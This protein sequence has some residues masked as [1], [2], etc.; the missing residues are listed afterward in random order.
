MKFIADKQTLEDLNLLGRYKPHSIYSLFNQVK[1]SGGERLLEE[2]F[3]HPLTD[4]KS[5]NLRSR[6][7]KYFQDK[8]LQFPLGSEDFGIMENYLTMGTSGNYLSAIAKG[9]YN[10][11]TGSLLRDDQFEIVHSG[12][13]ASMAGLKVLHVFFKGLAEEPG[14]PYHEEVGIFNNILSDPRLG[15]LF[16]NRDAAP[17]SVMEVA[18]YDFLLRHT[19]KKHMEQMLG[20]IYKLD[21]YMAV[22]EVARSRGYRY[23]N[24]LPKSENRFNT[25]AL[26]HPGLENA[27]ANPLSFNSDHNLLFLTGAN[28]AGKSTFMKAFGIS[29]YMAHMGFPVAAEGMEFSVKDGIY[30]SINVPDNLTLGLSHFYAEVLRV[31]KVAEEVASG[32][33][34]VILFDELFKG[35]N[36]KDAYDGTLTVT[37]AFARYAKCLFMVSTHIV[38]VAEALQQKSNTIQYVCLPTVMEGQV[39]RYTYRVTEGIT[40]D[41]QGMTIIQN[42]GILE[43][44][45]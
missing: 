2:M 40:A 26:W 5:I 23:A 20:H 14:S 37:A 43:L 31:K 44:L 41:R 1:T 39:P 21:V 27:I 36:V 30:S 35:T 19:L 28:M 16:E 34:L 8:N 42:E 17:F 11:I 38:E 6:I 18:K 33:E 25:R 24:D 7:F 9:F 3:R 22:A 10:K 4:F 45:K 13:M 15:W 32:K 29:G 12:L